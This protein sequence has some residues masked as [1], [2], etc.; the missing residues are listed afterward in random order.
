MVNLNLAGLLITLILFLEFTKKKEHKNLLTKK[1]GNKKDDKTSIGRYNKK[2][3]LSQENINLVKKEI[4]KHS[5]I[6]DVKR[7][8]AKIE[9]EILSRE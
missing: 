9:K 2:L 4:E 1:G 8:L 7:V 6:S 5:E 3:K